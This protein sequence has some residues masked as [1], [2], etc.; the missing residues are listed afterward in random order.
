MELRPM[1]EY[2]MQLQEM[3]TEIN[4]SVK[5]IEKE[6]GKNWFEFKEHINESIPIRLK[7]ENHEIK[8]QGVDRIVALL[9]INVVGIV[10][11]FISVAVLWG[12]MNK[13]VEINTKRLFVIEEHFE[14]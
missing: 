10:I 7:V 5:N 6:I 14:K 8:L 4:I 12:A 3:M 1:C 9:Y 13:Q 11:A 2:H